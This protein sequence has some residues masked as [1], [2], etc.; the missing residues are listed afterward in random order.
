MTTDVIEIND[1]VVLI[2][3]TD[4]KEAEVFQCQLD[5]DIIGISF[6]GSGQVE[7]EVSYGKTL[8][9]FESRKGTAFSFLAINRCSFHIDSWNLSH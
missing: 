1:F 8:Q 9:S 4:A 2:D 5:D 7:M 6:Y 3:S